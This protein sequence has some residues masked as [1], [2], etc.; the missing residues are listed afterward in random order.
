MHHLD[1]PLQHE[2]GTSNTCLYELFGYL[3]KQVEILGGRAAIP[4]HLILL[5]PLCLHSLIVWLR[6]RLREEHTVHVGLT[7][8][9]GSASKLDGAAATAHTTTYCYYAIAVAIA[10]TLRRFPAIAYCIS[11]AVVVDT[12]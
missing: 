1:H 3:C 2:I 5:T 9:T 8:N 12:Y 10:A 11:V 6:S 7:D 4:L